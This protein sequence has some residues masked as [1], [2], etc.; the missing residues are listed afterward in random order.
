MSPS[1][2]SRN[3]DGF[4]ARGRRTVMVA[5]NAFGLGIDKPDIRYVM[6]YQSPASLEQ[7][8]QEAGRAGRD[9]RRANCIMLYSSGD[10]AIHEA[11][12]SRSRYD[13]QNELEVWRERPFGLVLPAENGTP[14]SLWTGAFDRVVLQRAQGKL[15][16]AEV[17]DF[18]TDEVDESSL[19][20]RTAYYGP[21]VEAYRRVLAAMTSIEP[22][23]IVARLAFLGADRVEAFRG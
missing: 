17:I 12:L 19:A 22:A 16:A 21:Q 15:V 9:G 5:T 20:E 13:A 1:E 10:R 8:V 3:Q 7:Y 14:E 2:R 4:M 18:K 23:R 6:H 11:L